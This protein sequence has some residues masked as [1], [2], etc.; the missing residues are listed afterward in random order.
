LSAEA[1][2][3]DHS[4][5]EAASMAFEVKRMASSGYEFVD[6]CPIFLQRM[7]TRNLIPNC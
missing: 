6:G 2:G 5:A 7:A 3:I 1:V 4:K